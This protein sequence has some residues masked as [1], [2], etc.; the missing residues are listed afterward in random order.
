MPNLLDRLMGRLG[1]WRILEGEQAVSYL[2]GVGPCLYQLYRYDSLCDTAVVEV[3]RER[4]RYFERG[5]VVG[6][7]VFRGVREIESRMYIKEGVLSTRPEL[8]GYTVSVV[9]EGRLDCECV[10]FAFYAPRLNDGRNGPACDA[11]IE[12]MDV[13]DLTG[14]RD[15]PKRII[16]DLTSVPSG[17]V[18]HIQLESSESHYDG[19]AICI[20]HP[21]HEDTPYTWHSFFRL[22]AVKFH[23]GRVVSELR[24]LEA[25]GVTRGT[26]VLIGS[27]STMYVQ[28]AS[29]GCEAYDKPYRRW[30]LWSTVGKLYY[31]SIGLR[32]DRMYRRS[33][34][35]LGPPMHRL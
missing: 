29:Y 26:V 24:R 30:Y 2:A 34:W 7:L 10:S 20:R 4:S 28:S 27:D 35:F 25:L 22:E 5:N 17:E 13:A 3:W 9:G 33:M 1:G 8:D 18:V 14:L 21:D 23:R 15:Q 31:R 6:V 16:R 11:G 19:L 12:L 32:S